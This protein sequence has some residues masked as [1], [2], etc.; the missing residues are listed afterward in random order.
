MWEYFFTYVVEYHALTWTEYTSIFYYCD[1][2]RTLSFPPNTT[3]IYLMISCEGELRNG[4]KYAKLAYLLP[5]SGNLGVQKRTIQLTSIDYP[6]IPSTAIATAVARESV[7]KT[8]ARGVG[9]WREA[10]TKRATMVTKVMPGLS[11]V[12]RVT[13]LLPPC[14]PTLD[15]DGDGGDGQRGWRKGASSRLAHAT[16]ELGLLHHRDGGN[17]KN[18]GDVVM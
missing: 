17:G 11:S 8:G 13:V 3:I 6:Q 14:A 18:D 1:F 7:V 16:S 9:A 12:Q 10:P 2:W 15:G 5:I 4:T